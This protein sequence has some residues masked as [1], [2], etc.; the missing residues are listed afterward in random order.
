MRQ[1]IK[2]SYTRAGYALIRAKA[3][4]SPALFSLFGTLLAV[5]TFAIPVAEAN[6]DFNVTYDAAAPAAPKVL[7]SLPV[8]AFATR[9]QRSATEG[10]TYHGISLAEL[11]DEVTTP[12]TVEERSR[13]D[14]I[15]FDRPGSDRKILL[16]RALLKKF[17]GILLAVT[18]RK[19]RLVLPKET[20][21][22][23]QSEGILI[24]ALG[25]REVSGVSLTSYDQRY[26]AVLLKRRTDPA[27]MRGEKLYV[28]NCLGCHAG[29]PGAGD[30]R[31]DL[32]TPEKMK[33]F[34]GEGTHPSVSGV[35]QWNELLDTKKSRSLASYLSAR[36]GEKAAASAVAR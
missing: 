26:A 22:K 29:A 28:Q 24:E 4:F 13:V 17:P 25:S 11:V 9:S 3:P 7:K 23:L 6:S 12:L 14:L 32:S 33:K 1:G 30:S 2:V 35:S 5:S 8:S 27:A 15:A 18:D 16:P 10:S 34:L 20:H 31:P 36:E 19:I 21:A